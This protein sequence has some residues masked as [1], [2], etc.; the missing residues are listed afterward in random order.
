M[1]EELL[2]LLVE[3]CARLMY[4]FSSFICRRKTAARSEDSKSSAD[5]LKL[6]AL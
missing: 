1:S 6:T 3:V 5:N 2:L 4:R